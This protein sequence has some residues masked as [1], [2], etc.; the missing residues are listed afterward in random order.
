[1]ALGDTSYPLYCKTGEEVDEQLNK[2]GGKRIAP[3]Q[4]CDVEYEDDANGW[5]NNVLEK[6][7]IKKS[8]SR[9]CR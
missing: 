7:S 4:K 1:M 5:F 8:D 9:Q 6:L 2:L 3:L